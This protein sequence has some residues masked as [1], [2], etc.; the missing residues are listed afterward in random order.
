MQC[1]DSDALDFVLAFAEAQKVTSLGLPWLPRGSDFTSPCRGA[2][3][4]PGQ[5]AEIPCTAWPKYQS[6]KQG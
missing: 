6:I 5:G 3:S 1:R 4:V 2:G